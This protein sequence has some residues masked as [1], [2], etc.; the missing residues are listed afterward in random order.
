MLNRHLPGGKNIMW[1]TDYPHSETTW[2]DSLAVMAKQFGGLTE[3]EYRPI[4]HD[5]AMRF[6]GLA[7]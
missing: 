3:A 2:P 7:A 1:S 5:N 6:F 4:V